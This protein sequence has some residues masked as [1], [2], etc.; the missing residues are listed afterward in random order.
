MIKLIRLPLLFCLATLGSTIITSCDNVTG[1][2]SA[3]M[4]LMQSGCNTQ[5]TIKSD[6]TAII[7]NSNG[8]EEKTYWERNSNHSIMVTD[9]NG[10]GY[11]YFIDFNREKIY[12]GA[13]DWPSDNDG[14]KYY[15]Y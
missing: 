3:D 2:Y 14:Y 7:T 4:T 13:K 15:K 12:Y 6:G 8:S 10:C 9:N 5:F 11:H 1:V